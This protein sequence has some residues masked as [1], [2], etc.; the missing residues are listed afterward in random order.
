M[1]RL[2]SPFLLTLSAVLSVVLFIGPASA[3]GYPTRP[4]KIIVPYTAGGSSDFTART[5]AEKLGPLLGGQVLVENKPGG[6]TLIATEFVVKSPADGYTLL[7]A[8]LT[9]YGAQPHLY[10]KLPYDVLKDLVPIN[11]AI[12]SPLVLS[13]HPSVP[14]RN[15]QELVAYAKANPGKVNF[16]SAGVGNTLQ[17]AT[18]LFKLKTGVTIVDVPYKGASQAVVDLLAGNIQM[19]ID[20]VQTPLQHINAGKLRA[21]GTTWDKR[22]SAL[23]NV[24]TFIEQGIDY[25]FGAMI[26]I[27]GPAGMPREIVTRV[28]GEMTKI[29]LMPDVREAFAKQAMEPLTFA[30]PEAYAAQFRKDVEEMG[31]LVR[32][33]GIQPQ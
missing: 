4:V 14:A 25:N 26:G 6:N 31:K 16:G 3:Q 21:L 19:M 7:L 10:K 24:P 5:L 23:P 29:M 33:A 17:L 15:V 2:T 8:G 12:I 9:T 28:H 18:E 20:L 22:A 1:L 30:T 32:A 13:V 27:M 11:N